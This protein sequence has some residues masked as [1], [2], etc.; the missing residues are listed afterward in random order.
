MVGEGTFTASG[1]PG[2]Y[3]RS[4]P[5]PAPRANVIIVHGY[6][7]HCA[8]YDHVAE[9][10]NARGFSVFSYDQR[11]HGRS[12][13]KKSYIER[14]DLFLSD[15]DDYLNEI[16]PDLGALPVFVLAHSMGGLVFTRYLQTRSFR[17]RAVVFSSPL[18]QLPPTSP[19][20]LAVAG[21]LSKLTPWLPVA[22][23]EAAAISRVQQEVNTYEADPLN[24]HGA[25]VARSGAELTRAVDAA[26]AD[27]SKITLPFLVMHGTAD[28]L[29]PV[30][31]SEF[32]HA[33]AASTEKVIKIYEGG[34]H[35]LMNDTIR[36]EVKSMVAD[37]LES[38]L[39]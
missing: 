39:A 10:L 11:G 26:R 1:T 3:Q 8:R 27:I 19:V 32:L 31:G 2:F 6:R 22:S 33:N 30:G 24:G 34:Y 21:V 14:F 35:E 29:A 18:L 5:A 25:I 12:P 38:R 23:L 16:K 7:E 17:P 28:R 13:G 36:E 4:W 37:W 9:T 20:L 15:L